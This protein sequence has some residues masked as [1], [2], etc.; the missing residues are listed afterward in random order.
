MKHT[1]SKNIYYT[2]AS[3]LCL[4]ASLTSLKPGL[5]EDNSHK[6]AKAEEKKS[7][8]QN[9]SNPNHF[10]NVEKNTLDLNRLKIDHM[11]RKSDQVF[12]PEREVRVATTTLMNLKKKSQASQKIYRKQGLGT[13]KLTGDQAFAMAKMMFS[14]R[15]FA[16]T[17]RNVKTFQNWTQI[18]Q[19]K[20]YL[21]S[22]FLLGRSYEY[23]GM[24]TKA[25]DSYMQ[26]IGTFITTI[27][28][29]NNTIT[30]VLENLL[31][32]VSFKSEKE[33]RKLGQLLIALTNLKLPENEKSEVLYYAAQAAAR[34]S[35]GEIATEWFKAAS[36]M[37]KDSRLKS[38]SLYYNSLIAIQNQNFKQAEKWLNQCLQI[39]GDGSRLYR[40]MA[41]LSL[42]RIAV[43][44]SQPRTAIKLYENIPKETLTYRNSL[45]ERIFLHLNLNEDEISREI[46]QEYLLNYPNG[47][48]A[49]AIRKIISYLDLRAGRID[50]AKKNIAS[51]SERLNEIDKFMAKNLHGEY[52]LSQRM[53][54]SLI[55]ITSGQIPNAPEIV[56]ANK[57]FN[58]IG[59]LKSRLGEI[60]S[61]IRN[62]V[63]TVGRTRLV[64]LKPAWIQRITQM[65]S[66]TEKT[67]TVGHQLISSE[68]MLYNKQLTPMERLE[69]STS[70]KR[71]FMLL[72]KPATLKR[73][74]MNWR[75]WV[76][77]AEYNI[78]L[79]QWH[80][81]IQN[82]RAETAGLYHY[83]LNSSL[84][85]AEKSD[86][87]LLHQKTLKL[88]KAVNRAVEIIRAQQTQNLVLTSPHHGLKSLMKQYAA[89]IYEEA[90]VIEKYRNKFNSPGQKYIAMDYMQ[91][92]K[93]WRHVT[94]KLYAQ[95]NTIEKDMSNNLGNMLANLDNAIDRHNLLMG[96]L[97]ESTKQLEKMLTKNS[98][99]LLS[100]YQNHVNK[101]IARNMKWQAD[102]DWIKW[103]QNQSVQGNV[104]EKINLEKKL[105]QENLKDLQQGSL[106]KWQS[107]H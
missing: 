103:Q 107:V 78:S 97:N 4:T 45:Y 25:V 49:P 87:I 65:V 43:H 68:K 81:K 55:G 74:H 71:R 26:Y 34:S 91:A 24:K 106:W 100:H 17:I 12:N 18:P 15:R 44:S 57:M 73:K 9:T 88:E 51:V 42:A 79:G 5:A 99:F 14:K 35:R 105:L 72:N 41:T 11:D 69:L 16:S 60:R 40:E 23:L 83:S 54:Q 21:E 101:R 95:I 85:E 93:L 98:S 104:M 62:L 94:E 77:M 20:K 47:K 32:L 1:A 7:G 102:L 33:N 63:Y 76:R 28:R 64:D 96:H 90:L 50:E 46:A 30:Q 38:R 86:L 31:P 39:E 48:D 80:Q 37:T 82:L 3:I 56:F 27:E 22:L 10:I 75:S 53:V 61:E 92:W 89:F 52:Q 67:L 2:T 58:K 19:P 66:L 8:H 29:P 36:K 70:E 84:T 59:N 6:K 13:Q